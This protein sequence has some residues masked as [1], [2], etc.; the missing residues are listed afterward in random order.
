[1]SASNSPD[2]IS[3]HELDWNRE[4]RETISARSLGQVAEVMSPRGGPRRKEGDVSPDAV[5]DQRIETIANIA[6]ESVNRQE[7]EP[8]QNE[9]FGQHSPDGNI[10][11]L[12]VTPSRSS[13]FARTPSLPQQPST[14][15]LSPLQVR[16]RSDEDPFDEGR[17]ADGREQ[18]GGRVF[19]LFQQ[20]KQRSNSVDSAGPAHSA[21]PS[22]APAGR[23]STMGRG[24]NF[25]RSSPGNDTATMNHATPVRLPQQRQDRGCESAMLDPDPENEH[26]SVVREVHSPTRRSR[27]AGALVPS[28]EDLASF[29]RANPGTSWLRCT[30]LLILSAVKTVL[31]SIGLLA[32]TTRV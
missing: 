23:A 26:P 6:P 24:F 12:P 1:M 13:T 2:R 14:D 17:T 29:P 25:N 31:H 10:T 11:L 7:L 22:P 20:A 30:A 19:S 3:L 5:R 28:R 8:D 15:T 16:V 21:T 9:A 18:D 32:I 27:S 4:P